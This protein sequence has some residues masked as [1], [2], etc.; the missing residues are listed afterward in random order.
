MAPDEGWPQKTSA[1]DL[2]AGREEASIT[3][4]GGIEGQASLWPPPVA[5]G[6]LA[7]LL[8]GKPTGLPPSAL[9]SLEPGLQ[10]FHGEGCLLLLGIRASAVVKLRGDE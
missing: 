3:L 2:G 5:A 4:E 1:W 9:L 8:G 10:R 7:H 6:P